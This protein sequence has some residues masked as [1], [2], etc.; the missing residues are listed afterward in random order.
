MNAYK[1]LIIGTVVVLIGGAL[2]FFAKEGG[3]SLIGKSVSGDSKGYG[4]SAMQVFSGLYE[5]TEKTGCKHPT[6]LSL[7]EDTTLDVVATIDGQE[8]GL[9][10]G[11]W[12][13]GTDGSLILV[14][15]STDENLG[16]VPR[17]LIAKKI[18]TLKI[19]GFSNK[20]SLFS[21]MN[22][23]SF[24]RIKSKGESQASIVSDEEA[25]QDVMQSQK[26]NQQPSSGNDEGGVSQVQQ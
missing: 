23:P 11:T 3:L 14:L 21:W 5:C 7:E 4:A 12:G 16:G 19:T 6:R 25:Q 9:G 18:S 10:Q 24:M 20:K 26:D 8:V 13:I 15:Q 2:Y 22:N 17:S 1:G